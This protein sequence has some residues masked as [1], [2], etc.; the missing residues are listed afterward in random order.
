MTTTRMASAREM[1]EERMR[2]LADQPNTSVLTTEYDTV[3][4]PWK[5]ARLRPIMQTITARAST[6]FRGTTDD[7]VLRKT[8]MEDPKI[9]EFQ[10]AHPKLF[11]AITDREMMQQERYRNSITAMLHVMER[12]ERGQLQGEHEAD[13]AA[14]DSIMSTLGAMEGGPGREGGGSV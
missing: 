11:W 2:D 7:F 5:V 6:E 9:L 8:L 1:M 3:R 14:T 4:E 13:A 10:R 12:K